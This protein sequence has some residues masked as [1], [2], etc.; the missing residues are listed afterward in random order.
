MRGVLYTTIPSG[1]VVGSPVDLNQFDGLR[2]I[3]VPVIASGD[4][5][6]QG[7]FDTTSANFTRIHNPTLPGSGFL[8]WCTLA[9]SMM[10]P[11]PTDFALPPYIRVETVNAQTDNRT[12]TLLAAR[13]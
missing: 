7:S 4:L 13:W 2:A 10:I 1:S 9:G 5:L 3:A 8:R 6:L 12:L 11:F